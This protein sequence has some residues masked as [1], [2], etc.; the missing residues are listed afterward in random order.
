VVSGRGIREKITSKVL[1]L[2]LGMLTWKAR[3]RHIQKRRRFS[4]DIKQ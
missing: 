4:I 2:T 1:L 3:I